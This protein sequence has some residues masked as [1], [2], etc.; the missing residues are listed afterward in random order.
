MRRIRHWITQRLLD[1][2]LLRPSVRRQ[3][4]ATL[5]LTDEVA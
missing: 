2:H 5:A 4:T 1:L 3:I